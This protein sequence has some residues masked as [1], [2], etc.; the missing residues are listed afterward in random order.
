MKN[1]VGSTDKIVRLV[2]AV[3][4][5]YFS[6][7]TNFETKLVQNILVV[8]SVILLITPIIGFCP[9]YKFFKI[10]TCKLR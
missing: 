10:N 2:L 4:I 6:F 5:G 3:A 9:I 1:N 8:V 7:T